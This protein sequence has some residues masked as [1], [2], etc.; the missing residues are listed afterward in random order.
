MNSYSCHCG[1]NELS[2]FGSDKNGFMTELN[3]QGTK[4]TLTQEK[5]QWFLCYN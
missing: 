2:E 3:S 1:C 4:S 5:P